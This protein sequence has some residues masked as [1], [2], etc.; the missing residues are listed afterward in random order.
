MDDESFRAPR[1]PD[2]SLDDIALFHAGPGR[3][4]PLEG[5]PNRLIPTDQVYDPYTGQPMQWD[6]TRGLI[7]TIVDFL[8]HGG[9][10]RPLRLH[11]C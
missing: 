1:V 6:K 4:D 8:R 3:R 11:H 5:S 2:V 7:E 10:E 9:S